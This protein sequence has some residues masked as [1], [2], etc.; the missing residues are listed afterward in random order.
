MLLQRV[1]I[2][3]IVLKQSS[4]AILAQNYPLLMHITYESAIRYVCMF[5]IIKR[6]GWLPS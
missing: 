2:I 1:V 3:T 6:M 4:L 5:H